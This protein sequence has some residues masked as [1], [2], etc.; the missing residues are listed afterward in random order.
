MS[1]SRLLTPAEQGNSL[2]HIYAMVMTVNMQV[3]VCVL[4]CESLV[5]VNR[6]SLESRENNEMSLLSTHTH[7]THTIML[8]QKQQMKVQNK[9]NISTYIFTAWTSLMWLSPRSSQC[10]WHFRLNSR[11][12]VKA[13]HHHAV[14]AP[15]PIFTLN[16]IE[17]GTLGKRRRKRAPG[18]LPAINLCKQ[19]T[20]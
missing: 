16:R 8:Q 7:W 12:G 18:K 6:K 20:F 10:M 11:C 9:S 15:P 14:N 2:L 4:V 17:Q 3:C 19:L 13:R 5:Q 1:A